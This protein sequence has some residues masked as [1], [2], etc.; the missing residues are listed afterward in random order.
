MHTSATQVLAP[1]GVLRA[2]INIG[3][4]I[5]AYL[6]ANQQPQGISVDL[7][8]HLA[9]ALGVKAVCQV[10]Q[11]AIQSVEAV[12][13]GQADVGFFAIDPKRGENIAFTAPYVLIEGYYLVDKTSPIIENQQV[14]H[15]DHTVVVGQGSA[16]DLYLTRTLKQARILR[17][18][19]SQAVVETFVKGQYAV[20]A[21]VKQQLM[22][23]AQPYP[24]LK[25][26]NDRFMVIEQAMGVAKARGFEAI[27]FL[28]S[29]IES[30]KASAFISDSINKHQ[31]AGAELAPSADPSQDP[32]Q[33]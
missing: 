11:T 13:T 28:R 26:L 23:D 10:V 3:N 20:A 7:A 6:D 31:V 21:G 9:S 30:T 27:L 18:A 29:F 24:N 22:L 19:S 17:A 4:P 14:D 8:H 16:Y 1:T 5:L 2:T 25:L 32:L 33:R 12:E 15:A